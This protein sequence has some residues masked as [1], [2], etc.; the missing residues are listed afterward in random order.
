MTYQ[1]CKHN[2]RH[3]CSE[4]V[5]FGVS[6]QRSILILFVP[7]ALE[8]DLRVIGGFD[9][10][11]DCY[12]QSSRSFVP[13]LSISRDSRPTKLNKRKKNKILIHIHTFRR[14]R[15]FYVVCC[16]F[17]TEK[18]LSSLLVPSLTILCTQFQFFLFSYSEIQPHKFFSDIL[19]SLL[20]P[21]TFLHWFLLKFTYF[22]TEI[23][24]WIRLWCF[25]LSLFACRGVFSESI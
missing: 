5:S 25:N 9:R 13:V 4:F 20:S 6:V 12:T 3:N 18:D 7:Q 10:I 1:I 16:R 23:I 24:D 19:N 17:H 15:S 8:S 14:H 21:S 11:L 22:C 2:F